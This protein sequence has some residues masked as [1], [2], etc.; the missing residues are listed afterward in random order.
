[1]QFGIHRAHW[2]IKMASTEPKISKLGA[3]VI[4]R[5]TKTPGACEIFRKPGSGTSQSVIMGA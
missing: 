2:A 1:M 3:V 5:D 4:T